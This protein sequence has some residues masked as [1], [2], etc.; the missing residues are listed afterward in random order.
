MILMPHALFQTDGRTVRFRASARSQRKTPLLSPMSEGKERR[1]GDRSEIE[2]LSGDLYAELDQHFNSFPQ[3]RYSCSR[4]IA[5]QLSLRLLKA[6]RV[7]DSVHGVCH[8][9]GFWNL[10]HA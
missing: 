7:P 6:T 5:I 8:L 10:A 4:A 3:Q 9:G 2:E 1:G